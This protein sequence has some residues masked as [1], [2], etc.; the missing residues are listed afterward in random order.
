[1]S[2]WTMTSLA[3]NLLV[4]VH[5]CIRQHG[6]KYASKMLHQWNAAFYKG[7]ILVNLKEF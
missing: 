3:K 2:D 7:H 6:F 1:M 5:P 4:A